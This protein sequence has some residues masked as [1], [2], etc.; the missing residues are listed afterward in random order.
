MPPPPT[1]PPPAT[2]IARLLGSALIL[3][4][5]ASCGEFKTDRFTG[6]LPV[7]PKDTVAPLPDAEPPC[8]ALVAL[9]LT[10]AEDP[11]ITDLVVGEPHHRILVEETGEATLW[12]PTAGSVLPAG[13]AIDPLTGALSGVPTEAGEGSFSVQVTADDPCYTLDVQEYPYVVSVQCQDDADCAGRVSSEFRESGGKAWCGDEDRCLLSNGCPNDPRQRVRFLRAGDPLP[14]AG[15]D[16]LV[17]GGEVIRHARIQG[18]KNPDDY[19]RQLLVLFEEPDAAVWRLDYTLPNNWPLPLRDGDPVVLRVDHGPTAGSEL[20]RI[21]GPGGPA[22]LVQGFWVPGGLPPALPLPALDTLLP[23]A[24]PS[25]GDPCGAQI[26]AAAT[27]SWDAESWTL[28]PSD[29][30]WIPDPSSP[31]SGPQGLLARLGWTQFREAVPADPACAKTAPVELSAVF[32]PADDCPGAVA[33]AESAQDLHAGQALAEPPAFEISGWESFSPAPGGVISGASWS[34][35]EDPFGGGFGHIEALPS[36]LPDPVGLGNRRLVAGAVG[37]YQVGLAVA[38]QEGRQ[39]CITDAIRFLVFPDPEIAVRAELI[40]L[41]FGTPAAD[42]DDVLELHMRPSGSAAWGDPDRVCSP[43]SPLPELFEGAQCA[44]ADLPVGRPALATLQAL[45]PT[46]TYGFALRAPPT[47]TAPMVHAPG[48]DRRIF[49]RL[50]CNTELLDFAL[51]EGFSL[52]AGDLVE[53]ARVAPGCV[54]ES[55]L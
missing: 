50:Y 47:N 1:S 22:H 40:W 9:R 45:A 48:E 51:P 17:T 34:V 15:V 55:G 49:L 14:P 29:V 41:P 2:I 46:K 53:V 26:P 4:L 20:L 25:F 31:G 16:G 8:E 27:F 36:A 24:C 44:A 39:S 33:K 18:Q 52:A 42:G 11:G 19:R 37:E 5:A 30:A 43:A 35:E 13:M 54:L 3:L 6:E 21:E 7:P 12:L 23:L 28:A 38:D 32:L 10:P